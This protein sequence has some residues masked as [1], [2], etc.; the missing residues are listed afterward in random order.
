MQT[1]FYSF[2]YISAKFY[3]NASQKVTISDA[4]YP[5]DTWTARYWSDSKRFNWWLW[6][7]CIRQL[8]MA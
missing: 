3:Q 6:K 8:S 4:I 7:G 2:L 1:L 5:I